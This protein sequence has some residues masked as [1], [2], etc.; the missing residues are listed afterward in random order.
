LR[1]GSEK[2]GLILEVCDLTKTFGSVVA[3]NHVNFDVHPGE[4]HCLLGENGAGKTTLMECVYGFYHLDSGEIYF[5]DKEVVIRS[6]HEAIRLGIGMVHQHYELI[7][8]HSILENIILGV[9]A[10]GLLIDEKAAEQR[11]TDLCGQYQVDLDPH[12]MVWQLSVGEKQWVEILKALYEGVDLLILDEPTAVLTPQEAESL[13]ATLREMRERGLSIVLVTHKLN[14]VLE[15]SDRVTVLRKGKLVDTVGTAEV[16]K[17]DL[18]C[19]MVGRE[20]IFRVH[21]EDHQAGE[22]VLDVQDL[23]AD[24]EMGH[25]ALCGIDFDLYEGEILALAGVS[26]NGQRELFE[27]LVGV[28]EASQGDVC[29]VGESILGKTPRQIDEMGIVHIPSDR[30]SEGLVL[31]FSIKE[32]LI[33]GKHWSAPVRNGISL[34]WRYIDD[35]AEKSITDYDI[36]APSID[37]R[38]RSLSGGNMQKVILAR[39]LQGS[40]KI[41]IA[42]QPCR[43][44]DVG[45]IEYVHGLLLEKRMQGVAVLL[46]SE[47]LD[48]IFTLADRIAVIYHGQIVGLYPAQDI[49]IDQIGLAMAGEKDQ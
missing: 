19:M 29:V 42:N 39:E 27:V 41:L 13:F 11:L 20:V 33:L 15:I 22:K 48:E 8:T 32:N 43:G 37:H 25:S 26:G 28:R 35:T 3:N 12:M 47:D 17:Q 44:L 36:V 14:E 30:M 6:P 7:E 4:I 40:P 21:K 34:D 2:S 23:H 38:T 46:I 24:H 31:E 18:A 49:T 16:T 9:E 10:K 45:V 5:K 1:A